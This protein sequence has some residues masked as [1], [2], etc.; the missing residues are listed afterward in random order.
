MYRVRKYLR[1][2]QQFFAPPC[3]L[4]KSTP[5]QKTNK[6]SVFPGVTSCTNPEKKKKEEEEKNTCTSPPPLLTRR[7][8]PY[9]THRPAVG[10]TFLGQM[11]HGGRR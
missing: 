5:D 9:G 1:E 8:L 11:R 3:S 7:E 10:C 6:H 4:R 2:D